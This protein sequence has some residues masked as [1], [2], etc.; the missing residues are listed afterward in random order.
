MILLTSSAP[1]CNR[2]MSISPHG[3]RSNP[4][5]NH[6]WVIDSGASVHCTSDP[7]LLTSVY[8]K[9]PPVLIK[10]ADNRTLQAHAVGTAILSLLDQ[11]HKTHHVT[12]HNVIY[13]PNFHTNLLSVRRLWLDNHIMCR[14]DPHNYLQDSPSGTK[15][16][17]TYDQQ[18]V[19]SH[20]TNVSSIRVVDDDLIHARFSHASA[21]RL[22]KLATRSIGFPRSSHDSI[23]LDPTA[24]DACNAGAA[25]RRPF[26]SHTNPSR[27]SYFGARL[28]SDLCGPFPKSIDSYVYMLNIVD[29]HT[30]Y[31][32]VYFLHSKS[33]NEVKV[34]LE[35][36]LHEFRSQLPHD[37]AKPIRWHTDNG[38]EFISSDLQ[39]FCNEF[40]IKRSFS[41]PYAPPQNAHAERM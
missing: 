4:H 29:A 3:I 24:C 40:A 13:H 1:A 37:P 34:C 7:T 21:R 22:D 15:F 35:S 38:G 5:R 14:F 32:Q 11:H 33:S 28:S 9:H 17:I 19:S 30:N 41:T 36:Y 27:Y 16:P 23:V 20:V 39:T 31:L 6:K 2:C 10:V 8:Y 18:Y 26:Q 25:R 12:L